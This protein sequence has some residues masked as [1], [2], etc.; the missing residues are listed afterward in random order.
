MEKGLYDECLK[1]CDEGI[2]LARKCLL[3]LRR[4]QKDLLKREIAI[5]EWVNLTKLL[6][7]II[8]L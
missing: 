6:T 1:A 4:L 2:E 7:T 3:D 5:K 8:F